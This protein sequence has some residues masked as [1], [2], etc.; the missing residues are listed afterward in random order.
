MP[1]TL[2]EDRRLARLDLN[3]LS[4]QLKRGVVTDGPSDWKYRA[5]DHVSKRVE[6]RAV[7]ALGSWWSK[8]SVLPVSSEAMRFN[9]SA[10]SEVRQDLH[11]P[12]TVIA[13]EWQTQ[14]TQWRPSA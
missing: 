1:T 4:C 8:I 14:T 5:Q 3:T 2:R 9:S 11:H 12:D 13:R 6:P 7:A 10:M